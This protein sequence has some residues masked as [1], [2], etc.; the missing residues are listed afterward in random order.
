MVDC[1]IKTFVYRG[2]VQ[3]IH[4]HIS[5]FTCR[6]SVESFESGGSQSAEKT[7]WSLKDREGCRSA[8]RDGHFRLSLA[9]QEPRTFRVDR[10]AYFSLPSTHRSNSLPPYDKVANRLTTRSIH[11]SSKR[12][13]AAS[14]R[15][16]KASTRSTLR[17]RLDRG[18]EVQNGLQIGRV[19]PGK[20]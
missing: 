10:A 8:G 20:A 5:S 2:S 1:N 17:R 3:R 6:C 7:L 16:R 4:G 11:V 12:S 19:T 14:T 13:M 18:L 15:I 9:P